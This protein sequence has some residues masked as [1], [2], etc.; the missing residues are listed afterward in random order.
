MR[1]D[2]E[3]L[4]APARSVLGRPALGDQFMEQPRVMHKFHRGTDRAALRENTRNNIVRACAE[5]EPDIAAD[6]GREAEANAVGAGA[7]KRASPVAEEKWFRAEVAAIGPVDDERQPG[8]ERG[9]IAAIDRD[10]DLVAAGCERVREIGGPECFG[11]VDAADEAGKNED[12]E[13]AGRARGEAGVVD[14]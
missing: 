3:G 9:I 5:R 2:C 11:P 14:D 8:E 4:N 7:K 6:E 10:F 13:F 1:A 12:V